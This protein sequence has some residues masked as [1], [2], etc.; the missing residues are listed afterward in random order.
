VSNS[1]RL[2]LNADL[3]LGQ[4]GKKMGSTRN[5]SRPPAQAGSQTE[6]VKGGSLVPAGTEELRVR[7]QQLSLRE[8]L[9]RHHFLLERL[10]AASAR[11]IEALD[12]GDA[13][14]AIGEIIANLIGSEE[15]A[16][17]HYFPLV[18]AFKLA[19]SSGV[20]NDI[21]RAFGSGAGFL[22]RAAHGQASQFPERQLNTPLLSYEKNLTACIVLKSSNEVAGVI[23]ILGLLPQKSCLEWAD[24]ELLK[25]LELYGAV[26]LKFQRLQQERVG[27]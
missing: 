16:I 15:V 26:A 25:F 19:W 21:L 24:F 9:E 6:P 5:G 13:C 17:F 12:H 3:T 11:L 2:E 18:R 14:E 20:E 22:G 7:V 4:R 1:K 10:N 27:P 23:A 8:Q